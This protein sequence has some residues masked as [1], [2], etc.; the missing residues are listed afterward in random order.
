[1]ITCPCG[2]EALYGKSKQPKIIKQK[3]FVLDKTMLNL[4]IVKK[5]NL[6]K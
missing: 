3:Q 5:I 4:L 2:L 6:K 1:M